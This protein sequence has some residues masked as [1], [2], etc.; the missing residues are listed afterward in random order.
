ME[1][2]DRKNDKDLLQ[3]LLAE[4]AKAANEIACAEKDIRKAQSRLS[5]VVMLA[6]TLINRNKE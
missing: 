4:A 3:S 6:N 2:L 5:F 1:L